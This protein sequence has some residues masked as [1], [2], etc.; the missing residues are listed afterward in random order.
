MRAK[1]PL[2]YAINPFDSHL[3]HL[4][5]QLLYSPMLANPLEVQ[6][7]SNVPFLLGAGP[8]GAVLAEAVLP[9]QDE[10]PAPAR[11]RTTCGMP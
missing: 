9:R 8:G 2:A 4:F 10:D 11:Q 3:L 1:A 7:Y 6:Y 5:M